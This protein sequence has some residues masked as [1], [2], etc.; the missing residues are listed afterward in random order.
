MNIRIEKISKKFGSMWALEEVS[1]ELEPG[2][3]VGVLGANGAG[4]TTLLN[5][6]AGIVTPSQGTIAGCL[7]KAEV[8]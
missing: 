6:L 5:C 7:A 2:Q 1:L 8:R 3:V 4:K